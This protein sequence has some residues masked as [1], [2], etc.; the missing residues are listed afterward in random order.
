MNIECFDQHGL[1]PRNSLAFQMSSE[2]C[3]IEITSGDSTPEI[4]LPQP[5]IW[6]RGDLDCSRQFRAPILPARNDEDVAI[7]ENFPRGG[8]RWKEPFD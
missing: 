2:V 4:V 8:A 3:R 1:F 6:L 5:S 7:A